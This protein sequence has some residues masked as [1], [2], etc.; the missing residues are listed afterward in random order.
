MKG[1]AVWRRDEARTAES[2]SNYALGLAADMKEGGAVGLGCVEERVALFRAEMRDIDMGG[3]VGREQV[4]LSSGCGRGQGLAQAQDGQGAQQVACIDED[5]I[6]H[7]GGATLT[8]FSR[9]RECWAFMGDGA[10]V[11]V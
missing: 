6:G 11:G 7:V 3:G 1:G 10:Q 5:R 8:C 4:H 9:L 2:R